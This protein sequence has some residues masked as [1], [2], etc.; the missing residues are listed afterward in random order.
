MIKYLYK[1]IWQVCFAV[2]NKI[3]THI[4][5]ILL[6]IMGV[7]K[8]KG[9]KSFGAI[10]LLRINKSA[11]RIH[12]G[13]NC[14]FNNFNGVGW[15]CKCSLWV[16]NQAEL[17]IDDNCGF[18]GVTI[19]VSEKI[20]IGKNVKI[21]GGTRIFDTNFHP[22]D[23]M[24]RRYS[25]EGTKTAP[26]IIED[27]VFIGTNCIICKGVTIGAKSIIAAGSVVT[28]SI[29]SGEIWG[30]NPALFIKKILE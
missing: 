9:I 12:I 26:V 4:F 7:S 17:F 24:K 2:S 27:D 15:Y 30:G 29:P 21:G 19:S 13:N 3:Y 14:I 22:L 6:T 8:G 25:N 23:Y 11:G 1:A 28:K 18:N 16:R 10:P 5:R 20:I